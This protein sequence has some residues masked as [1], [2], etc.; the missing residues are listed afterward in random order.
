MS[1]YLNKQEVCEKLQISKKLLNRLIK[2]GDLKAI[3]ISERVTRFD[4]ADIE[5]WLESKTVGGH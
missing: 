3:V 4:S 2:R 1:S 5:L